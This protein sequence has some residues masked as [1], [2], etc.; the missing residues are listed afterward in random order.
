MARRRE[1]KG[2]VK[3]LALSLNSRNSDHCGYW[4]TGQ[5]QAF[6][7]REN[8]NSIVI[9]I[10][11]NKITP[12]TTE[13]SKLLELCGEQLKKQFTARKMPLSW[14]DKAEFMMS[15]NQ[16][17]DPKLHRYRRTSGTPYI[18]QVTLVSDLGRKYEFKSGGFCHP[19]NPS[20]ERRRLGF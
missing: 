3:D 8:V 17:I 13:F 1:L 9:N 14:L 4:A 16:D 6:A 12:K 20:Q 11:E 18:C 10:L 5:L 7:E 2:I 19:H 15:F